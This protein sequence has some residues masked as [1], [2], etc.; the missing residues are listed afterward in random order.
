[1][2]NQGD[3]NSYIK[4]LFEIQIGKLNIANR[5]LTKDQEREEY[6]IEIYQ[7]EHQR[8]V[9]EVNRIDQIIRFKKDNI[10]RIDQRIVINTE[11]ITKLKKQRSK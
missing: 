10:L 2:T 3:S 9:Q 5:S 11:E 7:K 4:P 6:E 1:M 8:L